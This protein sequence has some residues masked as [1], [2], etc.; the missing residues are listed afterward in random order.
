MRNPEI[1]SEEDEEIFQGH[2]EEKKVNRRGF[3]KA[4]IGVAVGGATV[5]GGIELASKKNKPGMK[6]PLKNKPKNEG[7]RETEETLSRENIGIALDKDGKVNYFVVKNGI[8]LNTAKQFIEDAGYE[9]NFTNVDL[10]KKI[11]HIWVKPKPLD[12]KALDRAAERITGSKNKKD[13]D[14]EIIDNLIKKYGSKK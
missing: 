12:E 1:N 7:A 14:V 11:A 2:K 3:L 9:I 13:A 10:E 8:N 4:A 5:A 6:E